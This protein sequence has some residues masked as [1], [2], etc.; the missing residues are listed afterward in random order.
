M[1]LADLLMERFKVKTRAVRDPLGVSPIGAAAALILNN[2][3]NRL[4]FV[5]MNLSAAT[6]YIDLTQAVS[7]AV[8]LEVGLRLDPNGGF[9]T[10]IW[11]EDFQMVAWAWW[12][13]ATAAARLAIFEIV[14]E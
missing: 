1:P 11:D 2:N 10:M 8:G 5:I 9:V 14:E 6:V 7:A 12:S 13:A 4:G 3:P